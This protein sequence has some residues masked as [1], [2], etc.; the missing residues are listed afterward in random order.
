MSTDRTPDQW[1]EGFAFFRWHSLWW[2]GD[3]HTCEWKRGGV[4]RFMWEAGDR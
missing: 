3:E 1:G 4:C 2:P